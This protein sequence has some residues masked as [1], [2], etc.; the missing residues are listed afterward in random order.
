MQINGIEDRARK[1]LKKC[2][3]LIFGKGTKATQ[4]KEDG[5]SVE[6]TGQPY[7]PTNKQMKHEHRNRLYTF[8]K[9]KLKIDLRPYVK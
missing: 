3:Q 4:W 8:R 2:S 7:E 6:T 5:F 9:N 1:R